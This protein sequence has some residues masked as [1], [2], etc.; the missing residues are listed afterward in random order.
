LT[1]DVLHR[2]VQGDSQTTGT[3]RIAGFYVKLE[4]FNH[5][6]FEKFRAKLQVV[7]GQKRSRSRVA[8]SDGHDGG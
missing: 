1:G 5:V 2:I 4:F 8:W 3:A 7:D 6:P